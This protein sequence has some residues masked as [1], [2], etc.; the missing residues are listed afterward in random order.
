MSAFTIK[1]KDAIELTGGTVE[2]TNGIRV[3]TGGDIGLAHYPIYD[4]NYRPHLNGLI[5][6]HYW[7]REIG[8]ETID[9]F[10]LVMRR[11]MNEIMPYYNQMYQSA[12]IEYEALSTIDLQTANTGNTT[13][14][15]STH[16]EGSSD[17]SS[18][19]VS[20]TTP[21]TMLS[22]DADYASSAADSKAV[23]SSNQDGTLNTTLDST[24]DVHVTGYQGAASD[25][26]VRYRQSLINIDMMI[27]TEIEE[28]FMLVWDNSDSYFNHSLDG[29]M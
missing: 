20:S 5:I 21:Q 24:N 2:I 18:R 6:D 16:A 22:G 17:N 11:K 12:Q 23:S 9:M 15:Q 10:Q 19:A 3:L 13:Q 8:M 26:V 29:I 27:I 1:L 28:C 4:E 25:L 14:E 7:N